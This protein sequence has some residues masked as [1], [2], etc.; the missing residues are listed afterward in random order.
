[1]FEEHIRLEVDRWGK[2]EASTEKISDVN[3]KIN[4]SDQAYVLD[5]DKS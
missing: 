5:E 3:T 2:L 4:L 1:V